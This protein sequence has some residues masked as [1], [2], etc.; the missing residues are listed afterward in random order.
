MVELVGGLNG[1]TERKIT[2]QHDV[3]TP[4]RD[5]EDALHG[6]GTYPRDRGELGHEL[7]VGQAAQDAWVQLA[8]RHA[9]GEVSQRVDLPPGEPG[10]AELGRIYAKQFGGERRRPPNRAWMRA[11]VRRVATTGNLLSGDLERQ[12][13]VQVNG[14]SWA[15]H[16]RGRRLVVDEPRQ[17]GIGANFTPVWLP[18]N[19]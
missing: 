7:V 3:R 13:A 18:G 2:G 4:Q 5:E 1:L 15:S 10:R 17:H 11:R 14:G 8:V 19:G 6:P 16:A 9:P 12:G